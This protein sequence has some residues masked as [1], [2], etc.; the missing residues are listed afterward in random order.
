MSNSDYSLVLTPLIIKIIPDLIS[1]VF[2]TYVLRSFV[3]ELKRVVYDI[4]TDG[5][6]RV[7]RLREYY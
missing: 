5:L 4:F 7:L 2:L 6:L 3:L 1:I